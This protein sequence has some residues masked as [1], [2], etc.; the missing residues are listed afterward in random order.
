M[1]LIDSSQTTTPEGGSS[2]QTTTETSPAPATQ[3]AASYE[4]GQLVNA[5][6]TSGIV[7]EVSELGTDEESGETIYGY[8]IAVV[9]QFTDPIPESFVASGI[10]D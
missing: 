7:A 10:G 9:T 4:V 8:R 1:T 2:T 6:G 5:F 3:N